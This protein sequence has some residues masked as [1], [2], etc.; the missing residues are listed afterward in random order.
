M[1]KTMLFDHILNAGPVAILLLVVS[2]LAFTLLVDRLW[3]QLRYPIL[4]QKEFGRYRQILRLQECSKAEAYLAGLPAGSKVS[5]FST[6]SHGWKAATLVLLRNR[7]LEN[8]LRQQISIEWLE[9]ERRYLNARLRLVGLMGAIAP[10][11]GLLGTVFGIIEMFK[12]IAHSTGPVTP[13]LLAEGMWTAMV[14]T[15]LGLV[16]AIPALAA[17]HGLEQLSQARLQTIQDVLNKTNLVLLGKHVD[18]LSD[19][20]VKS[21]PPQGNNDEQDDVPSFSMASP[22]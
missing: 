7:Q 6:E 8:D 14:T 5:R 9:G 2:V 15:A 18:G 17:S 10:L 3:V 21:S 4:K 11:L 20:S 22:A 1:E 16:I 12:A 19:G 13:A